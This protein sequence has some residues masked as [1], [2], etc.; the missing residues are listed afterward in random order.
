MAIA[1]FAGL[2]PSFVCSDDPDQFVVFRDFG[3]RLD[4]GQKSPGL[5]LLH[6]T[7]QNLHGPNRSFA[8]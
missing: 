2:A 8:R 6:R 1:I 3:K 4:F 7:K 5:H